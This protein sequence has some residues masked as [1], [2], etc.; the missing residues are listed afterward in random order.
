MLEKYSKAEI[1]GFIE[2]GYKNL[3]DI[4]SKNAA[5]ALIRG[6][7]QSDVL[8]VMEIGSVLEFL[9]GL[10]IPRDYV[11]P[12]MLVRRALALLVAFNE[13]VNQLE[14]MVEDRAGDIQSYLPVHFEYL[15]AV[16]EKIV[17]VEAAYQLSDESVDRILLEEF[18]A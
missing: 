1:L 7:P 12:R 14:S 3:G 2:K 10:G 8:E 15:S 11:P 18:H 16:S 9:K 13:T 4:G 6:L 17:S 5:V